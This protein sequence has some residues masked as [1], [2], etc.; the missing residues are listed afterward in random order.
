MPLIYAIGDV[1]GRHDLLQA[2]LGAIRSDAAGRQARIVFLGDLVDRGPE[3]RQCIDLAFDTLEEFPGSRL[4]LGNH[5][6]FLLRFVDLPA[7]R[8]SIAKIWLANGGIAT[9][10]SYGLDDS[11]D[12]D[13]LAGRIA[14]TLPDHIA[15]LRAADWL[16]ETDSHVFVHGGIDPDMP[17]ARQEPR[18]TRWIRDKFLDFPGTLPKTVVHGHTITGSALPELH[19]HRIA[20]DTEHDYVDAL[21]SFFDQRSRRIRH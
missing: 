12:L 11:G 16:V 14:E 6:E 5:E 1:H 2:L 21:T 15:A 13:R 20:V 4:I 19:H 3:S 9:L 7:E 17:I 8:R 10:Q 18:I